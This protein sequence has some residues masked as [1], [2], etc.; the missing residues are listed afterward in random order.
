MI[1]CVEWHFANGVHLHAVVGCNN[2]GK[3]TPILGAFVAGGGNDHWRKSNPVGCPG[4]RLAPGFGNR[5]KPGTHADGW[6]Y[7]F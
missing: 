2:M 3:Y 1:G 4:S 7:K 5:W 6:V